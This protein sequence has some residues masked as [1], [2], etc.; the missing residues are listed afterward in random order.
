MD[1]QFNKAKRGVSM[2]ECLVSMSLIMLVLGLFVPDMEFGLPQRK[3]AAPAYTRITRRPPPVMFTSR[4]SAMVYFRRT[5]R[6]HSMHHNNHS[7]PTLTTADYK[8]SEAQRFRLAKR[9]E[10]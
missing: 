8:L 6:R 10:D 1:G 9:G 2:I 5:H 7:S 3:S 4:D